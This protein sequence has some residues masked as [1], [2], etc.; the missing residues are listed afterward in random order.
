ML[1]NSSDHAISRRIVV[2]SWNTPYASG[3]YKGQTSSIGGFR[4]VNNLGDFLGRVNYSCGGPNQTQPKCPGMRS[5]IGSVP[6][7]CD[8]SHIPPSST[9]VKFVSDSSDY[10][11][12]KSSC[13]KTMGQ[14]PK[15]RRIPAIVL[16]VHKG[17]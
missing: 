7:T 14:K 16:V 6:N 2:D 1:N 11:R 5:I 9:N 15:K 12:Y 10:I 17:T 4:R 8:G 13:P 3:E